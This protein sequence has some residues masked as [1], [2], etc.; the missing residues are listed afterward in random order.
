[1]KLTLMHY[2]H[3]KCICKNKKLY[4]HILTFSPDFFTTTKTGEIISRLTV[5]TAVIYNVIS[6]NISFFL[7]NS[8]LFVGGLLLLFLTNFKLSLLAFLVILLKEHARR[9][10][11]YMIR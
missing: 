11:Y 10:E 8:V 2:H 3:C 1:M 7:R 5:D 9:R 6:N 4:A